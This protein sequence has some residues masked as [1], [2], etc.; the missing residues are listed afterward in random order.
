[1]FAYTLYTE[2]AWLGTYI[3]LLHDEAI[4]QRKKVVNILFIDRSI[5]GAGALGS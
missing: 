5:N 1:M 2:S 3:Y 4:H